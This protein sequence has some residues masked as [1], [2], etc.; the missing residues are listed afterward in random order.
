MANVI[1]LEGKYDGREIIIEK[2]TT[3]EKCTFRHCVIKAVRNFVSNI[4]FKNC[5]FVE[6]VIGD[7]GTFLTSRFEECIFA[8]G[9]EFRDAKIN[10]SLFEK[11]T[12]TKAKFHCVSFTDNIFKR[13]AFTEGMQIYKTSMEGCEIRGGYMPPALR[14]RLSFINTFFISEDDKFQDIL[15]NAHSVL[16]NIQTDSKLVVK[17]N[18]NSRKT[19]LFCSEGL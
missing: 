7:H 13:C 10:Q 6:S 19:H 12:F 18:K 3:Y 4:K 8:N 17:E 9:V 5:I 1:Y 11:C 15:G 16:S 14:G 2:D